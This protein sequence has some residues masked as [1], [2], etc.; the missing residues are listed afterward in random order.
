LL[1]IVAKWVLVGRYCAAEKPLWSTFVWR[2]ELLNALHEHLAEPFL[3]GALTGT[4]FICWYF[5]LLGAKI[6][7]RVYLETTDFSEFDLARIGDEAALNA[8]CTV[9][10][11]LFEDRVMKISTIDIGPGCKVGAG[12]LVLYD[13]RMEPGASLGDLSLL[14]K[15]ETLP[16]GTRWEG[17]PARRE[18]G[19]GANQRG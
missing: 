15:G 19:T 17:I 13:T 6:G 14:M 1:T 8:D 9:Q 7:R 4:P 12:S 18:K 2:N 16:A 10:T 3:V 5:R 11:H